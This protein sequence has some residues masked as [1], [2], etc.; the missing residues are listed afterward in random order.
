MSKKNTPDQL[1]ILE[2]LEQERM[3]STAGISNVPDGVG[4]AATLLVALVA[5]IAANI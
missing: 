1:H 2:A 3:T 5:M 4:S